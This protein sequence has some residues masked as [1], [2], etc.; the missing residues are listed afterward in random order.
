MQTR[1]TPTSE[2]DKS[3]PA[4]P[5]PCKTHSPLVLSK[6][7]KRGMYLRLWRT[8]IKVVKMTTK[9]L[10]S[11]KYDIAKICGGITWQTHV[12]IGKA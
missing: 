2:V 5:R 1:Y 8:V 12:T 11:I 4:D 7:A 9:L 6:V 3:T 10:R